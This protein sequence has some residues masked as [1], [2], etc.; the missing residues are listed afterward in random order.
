MCCFS[1]CHL[2]ICGGREGETVSDGCVYLR[3]TVWGFF[4]RP[5]MGCWDVGE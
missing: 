1:S 2:V 4:G 3:V 5:L